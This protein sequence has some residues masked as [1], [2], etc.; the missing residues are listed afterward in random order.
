VGY[1]LDPD[2]EPALFDVLRLGLECED[3][4]ADVRDLDRLL[5]TVRASKADYVFHLAAQPLVRKSYVEPLVT[6][7]TNVMGTA[8]LLEG[9]RR[10]ARP[11]AVVVVTSDKCYE[12][13]QAGR[14][15]TEDDP[16]EGTTSIR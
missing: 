11:C 5:E 2:T 3:V 12:N 6:L 16:M 8:H 1:A 13:T 14:P 4:R 10:A 15:M 9:V 7:S